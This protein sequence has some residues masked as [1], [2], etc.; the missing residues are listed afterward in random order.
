MCFSDERTV[1]IYGEFGI[2]REDCLH[3]TPYGPKLFTPQAEKM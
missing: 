3:M 2:R 1:V